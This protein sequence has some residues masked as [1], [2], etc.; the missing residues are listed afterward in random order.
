MRTIIFDN[1]HGVDTDGK[2]SI[3]PNG[4]V[5]EEWEFNRIIKLRCISKMHRLRL[6]YH[7]LVPH[8]V[9]VSLKQRMLLEKAVAKKLGKTFLLSIHAD[10]FTNKYANGLTVFTSIKQNNS[11]MFGHIIVNE[12]AELGFKN[13]YDVDSEGFKG[14]DADFY[15]LKH[16][17]SPSALI[18]CGFMTNRNDV[19]QLFDSYFQEKIA[20]CLVRSFIKF[21]KM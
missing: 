4:E 8:V 14:R 17:V 15:I 11:D 9:D 3:M 19:K 12:C 20:D 6:P 2:C 13:R 21:Q 10:A 1:G 18:E 16:S 7:D 5:F